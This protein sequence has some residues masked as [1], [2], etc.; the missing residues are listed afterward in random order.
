MKAALL[1]ALLGVLILQVEHKEPPPGWFC[2]QHATVDPSHRCACKRECPNPDDPT[3]VR[4]DPECKAFCYQQHCHCPVH[5][6]P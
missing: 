2:A 4:E 5:G 1:A 6:C 3:F